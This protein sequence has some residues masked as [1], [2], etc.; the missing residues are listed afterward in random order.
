MTARPIP[1]RSTERT[2]LKGSKRKRRAPVRK[3]GALQ[4]RPAPGAAGP[5]PQDLLAGVGGLVARRLLHAVAVRVGAR[6]RALL[7]LALLR[8]H[9]FDLVSAVGGRV[10]ARA[11]LRALV[12]GRDAGRD[13]LAAAHDLG[14]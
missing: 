9:H 11:N 7:G 4:T 8:A 10:E 1:I 2:Y 5:R 14:L 6:A 12:D 3:P 13:R